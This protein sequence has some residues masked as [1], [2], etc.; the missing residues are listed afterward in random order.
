MTSCNPIN[1]SGREIS[2]RRAV[3]NG[4]THEVYARKVRS[5]QTQTGEQRAHN[6]MERMHRE[7]E[8]LVNGAH[9]KA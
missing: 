5:T 3:E 8:E 7:L 1:C 4:A 9:W 2:K 6:L